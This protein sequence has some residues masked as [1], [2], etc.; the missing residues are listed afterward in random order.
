MH[1]FFLEVL[2]LFACVFLKIGSSYAASWIKVGISSESY[3]CECRGPTHPIPTSSEPS[4]V[5]P[6]HHPS[7]CIQE[8]PWPWGPSFLGFPVGFGHSIIHIFCHLPLP[9]NVASLFRLLLWLIAI[10]SSCEVYY[11]MGQRWLY[12]AVQWYVGFFFLAFRNL[13]LSLMNMGSCGLGFQNQ[14]WA[15]KRYCCLGPTYFVLS[16]LRWSSAAVCDVTRASVSSC[17]F[18]F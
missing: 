5:V 17:L 15:Q 14:W 13:L 16:G 9:Y 18:S 10:I 12:P 1:F 3:S 4:H 6:T 8:W 11:S 2:C 7:P